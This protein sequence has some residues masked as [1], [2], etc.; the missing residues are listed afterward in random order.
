MLAA[1]GKMDF[2]STG[3]ICEANALSMHACMIATR[4][5]LVYWNDT[6]VRLIHTASQMRIKGLETYCTIDAGP[7][8]AFLTKREDLS[9]LKRRISKVFGVKKAI[10]CYP[11]ENA[12]ILDIEYD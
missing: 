6:T 1:I 9:R 2:T 3:E 4:P 8:V 10:E 11:A 5:A 7:H 12:K